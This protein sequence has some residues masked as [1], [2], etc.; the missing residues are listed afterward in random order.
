[1][2][3][4]RISGLVAPQRRRKPCRNHLQS[5]SDV[6]HGPVA[7]RFVQ[8]VHQRGLR[9][10]R[11]EN[12][13]FGTQS[14]YQRLLTDYTCS[15][16]TDFIVLTLR[17]LHKQLR[18]LVFDLHLAQNSCSIV[19][20]SDFSVRR[21]KDLIQPYEAAMPVK[22]LTIRVRAQERVPR[23]PRDV[24]TMLATVLAANM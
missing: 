1:M 23:G 8:A 9:A 14:S 19:C 15:S 18:D 2:Q 10:Y 22:S 16:I 12:R 5:V 24:R 6:C 20:D 13:C 4:Y 21:N 7:L 17:Q 11:S 3:Q